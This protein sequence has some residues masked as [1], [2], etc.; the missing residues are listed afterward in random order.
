MPWA[1]GDDDRHTHR[2]PVRGC[3]VTWGCD[4]PNCDPFE[5]CG[6]DHADLPEENDEDGA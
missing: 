1:P 5:P 6:G 4:D 2:C 3:A